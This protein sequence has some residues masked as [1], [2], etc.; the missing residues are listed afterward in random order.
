MSA[1]ATVAPVKSEPQRGLPSGNSNK[2]VMEVAVPRA[3]ELELHTLLDN[4]LTIG[5]SIVVPAFTKFAAASVGGKGVDP[6]RRSVAAATLHA[7]PP[8]R[9]LSNIHA[10]TPGLGTRVI[11]CTQL[12]V[13]LIICGVVIKSANKP[14]VM[15][16]LAKHVP[17]M[18]L[19]RSWLK[20]GIADKQDAVVDSVLRVLDVQA[21]PP[22]EVIK[23]S[24]IGSVVG[25]LS[26]KVF[27]KKKKT[28]EHVADGAYHHRDL[29]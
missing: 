11:R 21:P 15:R 29:H 7:P 12:H 3:F 19:L 9:A 14:R 28:S 13:R 10:S 5:D 26:H 6:V 25:D 22:A 17:W 2:R 16:R 8:H 4:K 23:K 20:Q 24:Q 18:Q 27:K 1:G